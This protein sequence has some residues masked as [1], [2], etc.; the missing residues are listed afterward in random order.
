MVRIRLTV[1]NISSVATVPIASF[2]DL[3]AGSWW[4]KLILLVYCLPI[5][6]FGMRGTN[7][8]GHGWHL[9]GAVCWQ[10]YVTSP[11][12]GESLRP[13]SKMRPSRQPL[14]APHSIAE[15]TSFLAL[16]PTNT[17]GPTFFRFI[18]ARVL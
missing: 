10:L 14:R 15:S 11:N 8:P 18:V 13:W 2:A 5:S 17:F 12:T 16:V 4:G 1:A 9:A 3:L 7:F 6:A